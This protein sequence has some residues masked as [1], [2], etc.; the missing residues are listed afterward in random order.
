MV[1]QQISSNA[2]KLKKIRDKIP[3]LK[4]VPDDLYFKLDSRGLYL[5]GPAIKRVR[6]RLEEKTGHFVMTY[7]RAIFDL[8]LPIETHLCALLEGAALNSQQLDNLKDAESLTIPLGVSL[9]IYR[10]PLK[11]IDPHQSWLSNLYNQKR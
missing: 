7:E 2:L 11:I 3:F 10:N 8:D 9:V 5:P 4:Q 1:E 6:E